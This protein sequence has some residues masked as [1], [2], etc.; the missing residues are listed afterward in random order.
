MKKILIVGGTGF[1]GYHL[2]KKLINKNLKV[3]SLSSRK[4]KKLRY[5]KGVKYLVCDITDKKKLK[6]II[7]NKFEYIVNLSG[8]VD[9]ANFKKTF[10]SH[11]LG[12][13]NLTEIFLKNPPIK[14]V[15]MGSSSEYGKL[16]SPHYE[17]LK[18][19][20]VS[21]Y[22]KAKLLATKHIINLYYK[23]KFPSVV[24]RLYQAYGPKQDPNRVIPYV[25]SQCAKNKTFPSSDGKQLRDFVHVYD[26]VNAIIKSLNSKNAEG[27]IINIGSGK[28]IQIKKIILKIKKKLKKGQPEF[29][30]LKMRKDETL[31]IYPR[32]SK[33]K[34]IINWKPKISFNKGLLQTIISYN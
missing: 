23:N 7:K 25:I 20:P 1:I 16:K 30:K 22:G 24:L 17:F 11:F 9:H 28:A 27:E 15:Q 12:C 8:Y 18:C 5:L 21:A 26:V 4:P 34:K 29:G 19:K 2:A 32:I 3:F 33:A 13:K 14:F 10:N 6:K 31:K